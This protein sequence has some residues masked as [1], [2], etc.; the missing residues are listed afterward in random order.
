M[1][2]TLPNLPYSYDALEPYIDAR[3]ME[4]HH[5]KHHQ[6]YVTNLN[7]ALEAHPALQAK[8]LDDLLKDLAAV[9]EGIRTA[10]R[11]HG[12]GVWNHSLF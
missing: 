5:S 7:K 11:N 1:A 8:T 9:P 4:I 3:T 2:F 10:V 12:G 6:A